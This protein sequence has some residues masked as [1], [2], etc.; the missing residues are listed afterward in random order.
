[1][2]DQGPSK[3]A[4]AFAAE[5][6]P[7]LIWVGVGVT[8]THRRTAADVFDSHCAELR[9][10]ME[11]IEGQCRTCVDHSNTLVSN[12]ERLQ[13]EVERLETTVFD[14]RIFCKASLDRSRR[15]QADNEALRDELKGVRDRIK[16][17]ANSD[18][19]IVAT[20]DHLLAQQKDGDDG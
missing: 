19:G 2:T 6:F 3:E 17:A 12:N 4:L 15:L 5:L 18:A 7:D 10:E 14:Q 13:A 11:R 8:A 20:I 16:F 1:M 9:A